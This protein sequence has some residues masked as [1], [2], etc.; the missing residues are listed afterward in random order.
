MS[1]VTPLDPGTPRR[2]ATP[3]VEVRESV[4]TT[5]FGRI[6]SAVAS[7]CGSVHAV[8]EDAHSA[9]DR[10]GTIYVVADGVGGG[11][12]AAMA[13]RRLVA[14]LHAALEVDGVAED[15]VCQAMLD[16]DRAIADSIAQVTDSPGA[17]T[18]ALCAPVNL[19]AS[20]W[21]VAWVGDCRVYLV[22]PGGSPRALTV[23]D[24]FERLQEAPPPGSTPDDPARMVGNGAVVRPNVALADVAQGE[25][26]AACSD[27][28]HKHLRPAEWQRVLD[29]DAAL[30]LRCEELIRVAR[31]N[32][33]T[34][35][36]TVLLMQRAGLSVPRLPWGAR[37]QGGQ[38]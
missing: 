17:A 10:S 29:S 19:T 13:S 15:T 12:L 26:L 23:D 6:V 16:A 36:A 38:R 8:N 37:R 4:H 27:G 5:L 21:L 20:K 34:D 25:L 32:G 18:V 11:A 35:D 3:A 14:H 31:A 22:P 7:S 2:V 24:T 33:S 1:L 30:P 28:V 9:I